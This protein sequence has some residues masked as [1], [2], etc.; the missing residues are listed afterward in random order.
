MQIVISTG[1]KT[2]IELVAGILNCSELCASFLVDGEQKCLAVLKTWCL[3]S[4]QEAQVC[5]KHYSLNQ[6]AANNRTRKQVY[7]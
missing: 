2:V 5:I 6:F 1:Y 4:F 7:K 3:S